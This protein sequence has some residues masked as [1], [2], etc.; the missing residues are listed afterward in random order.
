APGWFAIGILAGPLCCLYLC[1]LGKKPTTDDTESTDKKADRASF[2]I[3]VI[4]VIRGWPSLVP[5]LGTAGFLAVSLPRTAEHIMH[6]EHYQ[7]RSAL[8]SFGPLTGLLY[9]A[10]SLVDNL[11]PGILGVGGFSFPPP[12]VPVLLLLVI[13]AAVWWWRRAPDRRLL[14]VGLGAIA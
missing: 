10:R 14:L 8:E 6:L 5:L 12:V 9:S 3:G 13:A 11:L 7:G 1:P 4:R 2:L